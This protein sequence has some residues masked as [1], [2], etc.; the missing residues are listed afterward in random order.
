MYL[1]LRGQGDIVLPMCCTK[2]P[3]CSV[4]RARVEQGVSEASKEADDTPKANGSKGKRRM[5]GEE[6]P[7]GLRPKRAKVE[8]LLQPGVDVWM[9]EMG[10]LMWMA[11]STM[12]QIAVAMEQRNQIEEEKLKRKK[13]KES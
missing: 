10:L 8:V 4:N 13:E 5:V 3:M 1:A 12:I 6:E 11:M 7:E 2:N 9:A